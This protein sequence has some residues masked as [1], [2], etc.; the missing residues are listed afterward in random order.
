[1]RTYEVELIKNIVPLR[2]KL[3]GLLAL[4]NKPTFKDYLILQIKERSLHSRILA[5]K[6]DDT[7]RKCFLRR[8]CVDRAFYESSGLL[9]IL[10]ARFLVHCRATRIQTAVVR[11]NSTSDMSQVAWACLRTF[12]DFQARAIRHAANHIA[13]YTVLLLAQSMP[14]KVIP[15][16]QGL[17]EMVSFNW[18]ST[19]ASMP[20]K[21]FLI[22][23]TILK[24]F[25]PCQML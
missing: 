15:L 14:D 8:I 1:L 23:I 9:L 12:D 21:I 3:A 20:L 5:L 13:P 24:I 16:R 11:E 17:W 18:F 4:P 6:R 2:D 10:P 22:T 7:Y 25:Y 19:R